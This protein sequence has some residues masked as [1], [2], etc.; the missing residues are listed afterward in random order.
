MKAAL[1]D[2]ISERLKNAFLANFILSWIVVNHSIIF[3]L[4]IS[5]DLPNEKLDY[6][7]SLE[8]SWTT[9]IILPL[10]LVFSYVYILP[11][12]NLTLMRV[13]LRY[14]EPLL[15]THRNNEQI[16]HYDKKIELEDKRLD[17]TF[18]E[19]EREHELEEKRTKEQIKR[20]KAAEKEAQFLADKNVHETEIF[21]NVKAKREELEKITKLE[22]II[23][24]EKSLDQRESLLEMEKQRLSHLSFKYDVTKNQ[25]IWTTVDKPI[26]I[27]DRAIIDFVGTMGGVE[28]EKGKAENFPI[29]VGRGSMIPGF[30]DGLLGRKAGDET[31]I[32][33]KFPE[34]YQDNNLKGKDAQFKVKVKYVEVRV[35]PLNIL[36]DNLEQGS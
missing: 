3:Y 31:L 33:V 36:K 35:I 19:K 11:L 29:E 28:F 26:E 25:A 17:L 32:A 23:D 30:E 10:T 9:D 21:K 7:D 24:K 4:L 6:L 27:G 2:V 12:V 18:R 22:H 20:T 15:A 1:T 8:F 14:V 34:N 16:L 5:N 13:K